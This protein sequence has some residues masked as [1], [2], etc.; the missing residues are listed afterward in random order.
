M[1]EAAAAE[2]PSRR[3]LVVL[4]GL[5]A[6]GPLSM[7]LYLPSVPSLSTE[8]HTS[9]ALTQFTLS[10]CL[11]GLALD[12]FSRGQSQTVSDAAPL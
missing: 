6:F 1:I 2:R 8:L 10:A 12:N 3:T 5:S 11:I 4:G 7:D 9:P